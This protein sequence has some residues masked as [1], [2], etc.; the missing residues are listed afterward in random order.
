MFLMMPIMVSAADYDIN[1]YYIRANILEN[2]DVKVEE[3][4]VLDG[5]FNGYERDLMY[6]PVLDDE[7]ESSTIYQ[8]SDIKDVVIKAKYVDVFR[9]DLFQ[10]SGFKTFSE[11]SNAANGM[12]GVYTKKNLSDGYRYRMYYKSDDKKVAF[13]ISYTLKNVVVMH[14]DVAE[15]YW[16]FI[17]EGFEDDFE[18]VDIKVN[19]PQSDSSDYFRVW[20]H[21]VLYGN[22]EKIGDKGLHSSV[23]NLDAGEV[24]D[25]RLTFDKSLI[26]NMTN[27]KKSNTDFFNNILEI[28][29]KR[30]DEANK[31]R[32]ELLHKYNFVKYSTILFYIVIVVLGIFIYLKYGKSPKSGYYSKYNREFIDDY[33]VE[34]ID[35][36]MNK[37]ITPNAMSASIM[38][39]IYKKNISAI[40]LD[41]KSKKKKNYEFTLENIDKLNESEQILVEFLF[42]KVGKKRE[43]SEK[44][45]VFSTIDLKNYANGSKTCDTFIASYTKWKN[46]VLNIGKNEKFYETHG[47]PK[48]LGILVLIIAFIMFMYAMGL[49]IDFIPTYFLIVVAIIFFIYALLIDKKTIKGSEHYDKWRAFKNFL[50]DFGTFELKELP[51]IVLWERYLVYACIFGLAEMVQKSMNVR[52]EELNVAGVDYDYYP[53]FVYINMGNTIN[54]SVN[55]ALNSAYNRQAANY[56]NSHS[57]SS[58]GSGFGGGFSGG[59]GFS[60]GGGGRGF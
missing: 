23:N 34:V 24:V 4:M 20:A 48:V 22:V 33:N 54:A 21:G 41:S 3:I 46:N 57:S 36:L 45:K 2:G 51:E 17:G 59:S 18:N 42:D 43:N 30:A 14:N 58:S 32:E 27:V 37:K 35:Y 15:F 12:K 25:V 56:A 44:K 49:E 1:D 9:E 39:L 60:G 52:I 26:T 10:E 55:Q 19:L 5:S 38:N 11:L 31:L 7:Y 16:P 53:S 8:A 50:K 40:E 13:Y 47:T 28:E 29:G 6:L